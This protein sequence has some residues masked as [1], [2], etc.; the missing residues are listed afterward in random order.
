[1]VLFIY[2]AHNKDIMLC[3]LSTTYWW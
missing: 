2:T 1:M 3:I